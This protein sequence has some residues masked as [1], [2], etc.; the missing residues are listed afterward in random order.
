MDSY[1]P[2]SVEMGRSET[3]RY[4]ALFS[5]F[6]FRVIHIEVAHGIDTDSFIKSM[7]MFISHLMKSDLI[8]AVISKLEI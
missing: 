2:L 6:I 3:K 1:W 4:V 8:M 7:R 5:C